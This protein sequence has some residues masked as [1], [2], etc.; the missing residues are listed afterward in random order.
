MIMK[1]FEEIEA[2]KFLNIIKN[3][4][5]LIILVPY[6]LGGIKQLINLS[7]L[8]TELLDFFSIGQV[9]IDGIFITIKLLGY[10][11]LLILMK[12]SIKFLELINFGIIFLL[13]LMIFILI[14]SYFYDIVRNENEFYNLIFLLIYYGLIILTFNIII[15]SNFLKFYMY[16]FSLI[17]IIWFS[18]SKKYEIVNNNEI[19]KLVYKKYP[20][21][22]FQYSNDKFLIFNTNSNLNNNKFLILKNEELFNEKILLE[23]EKK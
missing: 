15:K 1:L 6:L 5:S 11:I 17:L 12:K 18:P 2:N 23:K 3:Y 10:F 14:V 9:L 16:A 19:L 8:S 20:N 4:L 13:I 21:A 22:T 7:I